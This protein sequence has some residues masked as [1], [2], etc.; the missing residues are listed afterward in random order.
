MDEVH[1]TLGRSNRESSEVRVSL[2]FLSKFSFG[3][4]GEMDDIA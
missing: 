2:L 4:K 3:D 1:P